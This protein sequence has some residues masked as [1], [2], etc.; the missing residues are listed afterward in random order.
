MSASAPSGAYEFRIEE[1]KSLRAEVAWLLKDYRALERNIAVL[2]GGL[3][4]WLFAAKW[5]HDAWRIT[6]VAWFLP[7]LFAG[8]GS[9]RAVGIMRAFGIYGNYL[10]RI[11]HH[12]GVKGWQ[13]FLSPGTHDE[14]TTAGYNSRR[15]IRQIGTAQ[16]AFIFWAVID[17][18]SLLVGVFFGTPLLKNLH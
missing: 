16:F 17:L 7:V 13:H 14:N 6:N 8:L 12:F 1:Y 10:W 9:V 11:E 2:C 4:S 18:I 15:K 5:P 3:L